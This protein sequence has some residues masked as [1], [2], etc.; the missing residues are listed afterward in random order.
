MQVKNKKRK[1]LYN[2]ETST[3]EDTSKEQPYL[4]PG[5]ETYEEYQTDLQ[6]HEPFKPDDKWHEQ[7]LQNNVQ[8]K[9]KLV[10]KAELQQKP[11]TGRNKAMLQMR[12]RVQFDEVKQ[13]AIEAAKETETK[14]DDEKAA[15][16]LPKSLDTLVYDD[17]V[18]EDDFLP[19]ALRKYQ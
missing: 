11:D 16:M 9:K 2:H 8:H 17:G 18:T 7:Q 1:V 10:E 15:R 6:T 5:T 13:Q 4:M 12:K 19:K 3:W 14:K